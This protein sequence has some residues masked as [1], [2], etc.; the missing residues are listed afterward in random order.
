MTRLYHTIKQDTGAQRR[1][2][3]EGGSECP[4]VGLRVSPLGL[5]DK[6]EKVFK[7][8]RVYEFI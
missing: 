1:G 8:S 4:L 5:T 6:Q 2:Q 7:N 3:T